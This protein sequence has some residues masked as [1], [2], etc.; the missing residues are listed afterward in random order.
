MFWKPIREI[1]SKSGVLHFRRWRIIETRWFNIYIHYIAKSDEDKHLH[2][3]PW[4]FISI[5]LSGGYV[6]KVIRPLVNYVENK[7]DDIFRVHTEAC[8]P[9]H[10]MRMESGDFH[11][12]KLIRPTWSLVFTGSRTGYKEGYFPYDWGYWIDGNIGCINH[13]KYRELKRD[14]LL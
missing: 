14:N 10:P 5:P 2:S 3:H 1:R 7:D 13:I 4:N 9:F 11:K 12:I 8:L 6:Q